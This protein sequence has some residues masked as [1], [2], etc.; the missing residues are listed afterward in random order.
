M[1]SCRKSIC[2]ITVNTRVKLVIQ[3]PTSLLDVNF[4][5]SRIILST[6]L[7]PTYCACVSEYYKNT[8]V[9][10]SQLAVSPKTNDCQIPE[11]VPDV[12][13]MNVSLYT[14]VSSLAM[15]EFVN[16]WLVTKLCND[17]SNAAPGQSHLRKLAENCNDE[18]E[19]ELTPAGTIKST[20]PVLWWGES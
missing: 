2:P 18:I 3:I 4:T 12:E 5:T 10:W 9:T 17:H 1:V 11:L 16:T 15:I 8:A 14:R 13:D 6:P 7:L 19:E 20:V